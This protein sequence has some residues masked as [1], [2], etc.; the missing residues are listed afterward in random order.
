MLP[1][2]SNSVFLSSSP[3]YHRTRSEPTRKGSSPS[4]PA[5][6]AVWLVFVSSPVTPVDQ[7][8][9]TICPVNSAGNISISF[10][11]QCGT[12]MLSP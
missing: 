12:F 10:C 3:M 4:S 7:Y 5:Y 11:T 1:P 6:A 8:S 2:Y 9:M